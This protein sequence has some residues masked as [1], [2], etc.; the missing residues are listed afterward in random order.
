MLKR[1]VENI[2]ISPDEAVG[3]ADS[4]MSI[5]VDSIKPGAVV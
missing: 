4:I 3:V 5:Y 2:G 1:C